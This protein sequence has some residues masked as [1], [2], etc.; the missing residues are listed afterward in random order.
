MWAQFYLGFQKVQTDT[1]IYQNIISTMHIEIKIPTLKNL[2][3][4]AMIL[5]IIIAAYLFLNLEW[6]F[7]E[8][9][10]L[11]KLV[12]FFGTPCIFM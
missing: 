7:M 1:S 2:F 12:H 8:V 6:S 4:Y 3:K 5:D 11:N 10:L 9:S